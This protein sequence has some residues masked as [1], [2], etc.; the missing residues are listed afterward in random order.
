MSADDLSRHVAQLDA[1]A[2]DLSALD[3]HAD[4]E[5]QSGR[6]GRWLVTPGVGVRTISSV[7]R[8]RSHGMHMVRVGSEVL[9][10]TTDDL[11]SVVLTAADLAVHGRSTLSTPSAGEYCLTSDRPILLR[12]PARRELWWFSLADELAPLGGLETAVRQMAGVDARLSLAVRHHHAGATAGS[13]GEE[14]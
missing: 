3:L 1:L 2:H 9:H 12:H 8:W 7:R 14:P 10:L 6:R 5:V 11:E 4:V 13:L